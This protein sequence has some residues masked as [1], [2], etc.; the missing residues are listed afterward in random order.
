MAEN[1]QEGEVA[2]RPIGESR[3][4]D[5]PPSFLQKDLDR[6]TFDDHLEVVDPI[7][8]SAEFL[9]QAPLHLGLPP[10]TIQHEA[11]VA[12]ILR[13]EVVRQVSWLRQP[14]RRVAA[15]GPL[16]EDAYPCER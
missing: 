16:P 10:E 15:E 14:G 13:E 11:Q 9:D 1:R 5:S 8:E 12:R 6:A 3:G 7:V 4:R 2:E